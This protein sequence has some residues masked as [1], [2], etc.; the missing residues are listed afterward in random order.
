MIQLAHGHNTHS[1][2]LSIYF[3]HQVFSDSNLTNVLG[4]RM[5]RQAC[6]L[7]TYVRGQYHISLNINEPSAKNEE[8]LLN[9]YIDQ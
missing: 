7:I 6:F 2:A 9:A 8:L 5:R 4:Q 3:G 1:I